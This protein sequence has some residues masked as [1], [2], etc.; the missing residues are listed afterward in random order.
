MK[1]KCHLRSLLVAAAFSS[2]ALAGSAGHAAE[3]LT[4]GS[5]ET[6]AIGGGNYTYP[7]LNIGTIGQI[8]ATQDG[9]TYAGSALVGATGY[10]AWYGGAPPAGQ[11]GA[12]FVA[13]QGTS[14]LAQTFT[15]TGAVLDL[16]W[17]AGGR[18]NFGSYNGDE[19]YDVKLNGLTLGSYSTISGEAFTAKSL[20]L[21]GL[22]NGGTYTLSFVG[23]AVGGADETSFI[24]KVSAT[25]GGVP[26]P[27]AWAL[28]IVGFG[29]VGAALRSKR[30]TFVAA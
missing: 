25:G 22:T 11:D 6:P 24:D 5:F 27:A 13:L 7:G 4:D 15:M 8:G 26:E 30:R 12:Q 9:W 2:A 28:M 19:T 3:L 16:S 29:G 17:L 14:T 23:K 1:I 21:G 20:H 18:P 10:N